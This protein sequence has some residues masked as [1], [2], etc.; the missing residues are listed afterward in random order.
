MTVECQVQWS[1]WCSLMYALDRINSNSNSKFKIQVEEDRRAPKTIITDPEELAE[2]RLT[3]R[4]QY[5]DLL[6]RYVKKYYCS[7]IILFFAGSIVRGSA[8]EVRK[9]ILLLDNNLARVAFAGFI[10]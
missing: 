2:Y 6:R 7:I 1:C 10:V 9:E 3:K 4:K 8:A 5:E